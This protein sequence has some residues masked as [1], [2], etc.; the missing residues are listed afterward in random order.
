MWGLIVRFQVY[1]LGT[2]SSKRGFTAKSSLLVSIGH[3]GGSTRIADQTNRPVSVPDLDSQVTPFLLHGHLNGL[4]IAPAF[5]MP[6]PKQVFPIVD[7]KK[8][9]SRHEHVVRWQPLA[10][11]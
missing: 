9:I 4:V 3:R 11:P 7:E 6:A 10:G 8:A 2:R 1:L 5:D